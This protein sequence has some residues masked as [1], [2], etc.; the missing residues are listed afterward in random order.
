MP[1][2]YAI[3]PFR[4]ALAADSPFPQRDIQ[5]WPLRRG[6]D[7][8]H[9]IIR[10]GCWPRRR[11]HLRQRH[12]AGLAPQRRPENQVGERQVG[13]QLPVGNERVQ[14]LKAGP[15][16]LRVPADEVGQGGHLAIIAPGPPPP[17]APAPPTPPPPP[18]LSPLL[19]PPR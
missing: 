1:H 9:D 10:K 12:P 3:H 14:P 6:Q 2:W 5:E 16:Q 15:G 8:S 18:P 17:P 4:V 19:P 13:Q 7:G 11:A